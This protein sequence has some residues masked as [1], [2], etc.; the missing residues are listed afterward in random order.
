MPIE[1]AEALYQQVFGLPPDLAFF[2]PGRVNLI[3]DHTDYNDGFVMPVAINL[4][5]ALAASRGGA[6]VELLSDELGPADPFDPNTCQPGTVTSWAEYPA[7]VSWALRDLGFRDLTPWTGCVASTL[8]IGSGLSSSAALEMVF[9]VAWNWADGLGL[10]PLEC[11]RVGQRCENGF[12]GLQSGLMDQLASMCGVAGHAVFADMRDASWEP[13]PLPS[14]WQLVVCHTGTE[15]RLAASGY[16]ERRMQCAEAA[17][18]LGVSSLR[19]IGVA[20]LDKLEDRVSAAVLRRARHVV[21]E[22]ARTLA[23]REA[24]VRHPDPDQVGR[25]M[26]ESHL[27]L[28]DDYE[29]STPALDAMATLAVSA[30]GCIGVRLTGA[31]FGGACVALVQ[32]DLAEPFCKAVGE[33]YASAIGKSPQL[34]LVEAVDG[35]H[36]VC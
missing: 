4:G 33:R 2:A 13:V 14:D 23:L 29:V 22:N 10:S 31:G 6:E 30:P 19:D 28:R 32:R 5:V 27:S 11:A 36:R 16:N 12:I 1:R 34:L 25:L 20:D 24:L 15:R 35:A 9:A 8:P 26:T 21:T 18:A 3:G 7:G 17:A